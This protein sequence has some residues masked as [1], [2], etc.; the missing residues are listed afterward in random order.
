VW[1]FGDG[2]SSTERNPSHTYNK[3]GAY[4]VTLTITGP[5]G[6]KS[7]TYTITASS[8]PDT[9]Y[10]ISGSITKFR[11]A[12]LKG[13]TMTLGGASQGA[14]TTDAGGN[15]TFTGL[16][17]GH[18]TI[19]PTLAGYVFNP[20]SQA[21]A[22][23][24]GDV[25]SISF[26]VNMSDPVS[27]LL[28]TMVNIPGGA[29][30]MGST[31]DT[32]G[33]AYFTMPVHE[34][35]LQA[36]EIGAYEVTQ[37]QYAALMSVNPSYFQTKGYPDSGNKPVEMVSFN[38]AREFCTKLSALTGRTFTLPSEAQWEYASRA[39]STGLYSFGDDDSLIGNYAWWWKN[40]NET[41]GSYGTHPVGAKL[42]NAWGL[43]DM[44]GN[45]W[46]WCLD[47]WHKNYSGAPNDG[48]AWE[49]ETGSYRMLRGGSWHYGFSFDLRSAHRHAHFLNIR[50]SSIGF[51]IVEVLNGE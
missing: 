16:A 27:A 48:S 43:Y 47:S 10:S 15:Y 35:T 22:I 23:N 41:G 8:N 14:I 3:A 29:F 1:D 46:E 36:F 37:A 6:S 31:D 2:A 51:R 24:L 7:K 9:A 19:T 28:S 45:V 38:D 30:M 20:V 25:T 18:Y 26:T 13:V 4:D 42:P 50:Y 44:H 5:C 34:V 39:G 32:G 12:P 49:P 17:N 21:V 40:S 33:L 11:G